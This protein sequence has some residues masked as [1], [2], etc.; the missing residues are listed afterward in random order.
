MDIS[1]NTTLEETLPWL[2]FKLNEQ[3]FAINSGNIETI[4]QLD[5]TISPMPDMPTCVRGIINLRGKIVPLVELRIVLGMN[6]FSVEQEEFD[7]ML[8]LRKQDHIHWVNELKSSLEENRD[9]TLSTDP[10]QC[11]FGKWYDNYKTN[12]QTIQYHL[13]KINDPHTM[14]HQSAVSA[15]NCKQAKDKGEQ[16]N[17]I[18]DVVEKETMESMGEVISLLD[19]TKDMFKESIKEMCIVLNQDERRLGLIVDEVIAVESLNLIAKTDDF[20][21]TFST[22]LVTQIAQSAST[23]KQVLVIDENELFG[24]LAE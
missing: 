13:N 16:I 23:E 19:E 5:Q 15:I 8:E 10:H 2:L 12:N 17:C 9:F 14:L 6:S 20:S 18:K 24:I 11:A 4:F 21:S 22:T 3:V 1:K 7:N